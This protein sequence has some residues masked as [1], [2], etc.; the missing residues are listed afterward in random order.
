[1]KI[2]KV[3]FCV[4]YDWELLKNSLPRVYAHADS[5]CLA[6][7]KDRKSWS[8]NKYEFDDAAFYAFVENIDTEKKILLYE[9]CFSKQELNARENCNRH[10]TLIAEKLG[11]GGWHIQIDSDEYFLDFEGFVAE[12]K[13]IHPNPTG[14]EK[15]VN[16]N[17]NLIPL[18]K[19]INEGYLYVN[20][21]KHIPENAP[22]ATNKPEY[23]RARNNGHFSILTPFVAL[24]ETW[25]RGETELWYKINNWGHAAEELEEKKKREAYFNLWKSLDKYNF[26]YVRNFHPATPPTWPALAFSPGK[27]IDEFLRNFKAPQFPLSSIQLMLRNSR[28]LARLRALLNF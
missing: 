6:V 20:F 3:G 4:S 5:I 9:D 23:L 13:R 14:A 28:N 18:I 21:T 10:R 12:L 16:V 22:F 8:G 25:A 27:N 19:R 17:V 2:I 26:E 11:K 15:P 24:H 7:D 1:M